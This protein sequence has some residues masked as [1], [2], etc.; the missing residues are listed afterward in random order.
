M[1]SKFF[2]YRPVFAMVI[3]IVIVIM[4]LV[5]LQRLPIAQYP[6]ITPPMV[7]VSTTYTGANATNVEQSD[8]VG[9]LEVEA[10]GD[11]AEF[12]FE[13][14]ANQLERHLFAGVAGGKINLAETTAANAPLDR[15]SLERLRTAGVGESRTRFGRRALVSR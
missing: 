7:N 11:A 1:F 14:A 12:D 3:A 10:L 6:D 9:V 2:I 4:G 5:A 8:Q 15:V 13:V